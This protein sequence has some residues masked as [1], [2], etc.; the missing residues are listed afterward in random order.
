[1]TVNDV[2]AAKYYNK[3]PKKRA[4]AGVLFFNKRGEVLIV[5]PN[6][7]EKW[8]WIGGSADEGEAPKTT[9]LRECQEEIGIIP[10]SL[11][12]AFV[13]YLPPQPTGQSDILQFLFASEAVDDNFINKLKL[14]ESEIADARF[15]PIDDLANYMHEYRARAIQTYWKNRQGRATL[16][17]EDSQLI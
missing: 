15:I 10:S 11:W 5:K 7:L 3:Q 4:G 1:M 2:D 9:A 12:L 14:Q 16:Y 8:L 17:L 6:Y 13:N